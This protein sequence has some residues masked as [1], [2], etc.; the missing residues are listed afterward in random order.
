MPRPWAVQPD[1]TRKTASAGFDYIFNSSKWWD[2]HG[3]W[4]MAQYQLTREVAPSISFPESHDTPRLF[5]ELQGNVEGMK[6]RYLFAALFSAGVMIPV[7]FEFGFRRKL[8]VVKTR[9]A[10]WERTDVDLS[11]YIGK[12]NEIKKAHPIFQEEAP[13]ELLPYDNPNILFMWK[14]STSTEEEALLILNKDIHQ[15]QHFWVPNLQD[16]VQAGRP[17][18]D[19]SPEYPLDFLPAPFDYGLRPG[20]GIVLVTRR[21][22]P[23][24]E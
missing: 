24:E 8:H 19:V 23:P 1:Q 14:G 11:P 13:T 5:E 2:F 3:R 7:G 10:Q 4:L 9:P 22:A 16:F 12:V 21:D 17:L 18:T 20:Q 6:Q 15:H